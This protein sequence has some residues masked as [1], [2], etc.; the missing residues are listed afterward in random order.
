MNNRFSTQGLKFSKVVYSLALYIRTVLTCTKGTQLRS[1][2]V[3]LVRHKNHSTVQG[4]KQVQYQE[5]ERR[6]QGWKI[7]AVGSLD[8]TADR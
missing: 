6:K 7:G 8:G 3:Q 4:K 5:E 1:K 2:I